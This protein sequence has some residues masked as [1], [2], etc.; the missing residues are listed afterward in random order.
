MLKI[1]IVKSEEIIKK[2]TAVIK[3]NKINN[4]S[5]MVIGGIDS[6]CISTMSKDDAKKYISCVYNEPLELTGTG[7]IVD[8]I[9]HIHVTLG[10][11]DK[12]TLMGHLQWGKVESWFVHVYINEF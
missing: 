5:L 2:V 11:E 7:E 12:T 6:C 9:I 4:A 1:E 3:K 10:R 8:G